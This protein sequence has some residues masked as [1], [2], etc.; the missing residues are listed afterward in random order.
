MLVKFSDLVTFNV[1][2]SCSRGYH[3]VFVI[4]WVGVHLPLR[5]RFNSKLGVHPYRFPIVWQHLPTI[6]GILCYL[7]KVKA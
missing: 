3:S 7:P 1:I 6:R 5:V 2:P 4:F